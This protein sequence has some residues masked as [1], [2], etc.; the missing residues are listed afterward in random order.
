L[1]TFTSCPPPRARFSGH[2]RDASLGYDKLRLVV[3]FPHVGQELLQ[4]ARRRPLHEDHQG[5]V[6][7]VLGQAERSYWAI[8]DHADTVHELIQSNADGTAGSNHSLVQHLDYDTSGKIVRAINAGGAAIVLTNLFSEY[9]FAGREWD[10]DASLYY[11]RARW[12]DAN[13]GRFT[14]EDPLSFAGGDANLYRYAAG[15]PVNFRDPSGQFPLLASALISLAVSSTGAYLEHEINGEEGSFGLSVNVGIGSG[16]IT[17]YSASVDVNGQS[18]GVT[19]FRS[20]PSLASQAF[21]GMS[22]SVGAPLSP[23][24]AIPGG[25]GYYVPY[26]NSS[27]FDSVSAVPNPDEL[28]EFTHPVL[29]RSAEEQVETWAHRLYS[30]PSDFQ[31]SGDASMVTH[32]DGSVEVFG[33]VYITEPDGFRYLYNPN[34]AELA[35]WNLYVTGKREYAEEVRPYTVA[36]SVDVIESGLFNPRGATQSLGLMAATPVVIA[37]HQPEQ[38]WGG[39]TAVVRVDP[40]YIG[41]SQR[42][43]GGNGRAAELRESM[44]GGWNG[45]AVD[46][47]ATS[48]GLVTV[49][50]TRIAVARELGIREVPVTIRLP[51]DPLPPSMLGRFGNARTWGEALQVRTGNQ[52]PPLPPTG[53]LDPPR[54]P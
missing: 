32:R 15:D 37:P 53:T 9:A 47:V 22:T 25:Y 5:R 8:T 21:S 38:R 40:N 48:K 52:R 3:D 35:L 46:A 49:D 13:T 6:H 19:A 7:T 31:I 50:N 2:V 36:L 42:T 29:G 43:A 54:M 23:G 30:H 44:K 41:F 27:F 4:L 18:T 16:G 34:T 26:E 51:S 17:D 14:S 33:E 45:P 10:G 11:N 20:Q 1:T 28:V 24:Q 39:G 12:Y